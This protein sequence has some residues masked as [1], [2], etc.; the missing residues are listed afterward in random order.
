M[1]PADATPR[2][3]SPDDEAA[4]APSAASLPEMPTRTPTQ[5]AAWLLRS[6]A[7]V[8][9]LAGI[10]GAI[11]APGVRGNTSEA[12]VDATDRAS[13]ALAY[14]LALHLVAMAAY[15][16]FCLL[17]DNALPAW[18]RTPLVGGGPIVVLALVFG[19]VRDRLP[20]GFPVVISATATCAALAGAVVAARAPHTRAVAGVLLSFAF[21]SIARLAA[22][23]LAA[24]AGDAASVQ[25]FAISRGL[26]TAGVLFDA[27]AQ[28]VA[29][30][31][32]GTRSRGAGQ[33]GSV[34]ALAG[35]FVV[36]L[37]VARGVHSG[38]AL[39]QAIAHTALADAPGIPQP[40][41]LDALAT[42][43]VP[44][45]LLVAVAVAAQ[46]RQEAVLLSIMATALVS[47]GAFDAPLRALCA[48]AAAQWAAL[49]SFDGRAMWRTLLAERARREA[50][51]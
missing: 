5:A 24:R 51:G 16:A 27:S 10:A 14:F 40:Y 7:W 41:A 21:A 6:E 32:L 22:W 29:V 19:V 1:N 38:A 15:G 39:W 25:M 50:D 23:E 9:G 17:R 28:L 18:L 48:V 46:P 33:L 11:L 43:L 42:F 36:T 2:T 47:R 35:A 34:A 8:A 31:W 49:A 45:S 37:G 26:A 20:P 30:T 3:S 13:N 44:A 4:S 12:V